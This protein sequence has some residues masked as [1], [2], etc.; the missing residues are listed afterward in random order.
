MSRADVSRRVTPTVD[1]LVRCDPVDGTRSWWHT[2]RWVGTKRAFSIWK[3]SSPAGRSP[4]PNLPYTRANKRLH[5][6]LK[7][8]AEGERVTRL[9]HE[10]EDRG[11]R[12]STEGWG[13]RRWRNDAARCQLLSS[14]RPDTR[15]SSTIVPLCSCRENKSAGWTRMERGKVAGTK[16]RT[17]WKRVWARMDRWTEVVDASGQTHLPLKQATRVETVFL[18]QQPA[19][20]VWIWAKESD[21]VGGWIVSRGRVPCDEPPLYVFSWNFCCNVNDFYFSSSV[22]P[23]VLFAFLRAHL[24]A[25]EWQTFPRGKGFYELAA[26][27]TPWSMIRIGRSTCSFL[28]QEKKLEKISFLFRL[29]IVPCYN[30]EVYRRIIHNIK[31][32]RKFGNSLQL[33]ITHQLFTIF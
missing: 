26:R 33:F 30:G 3:K 2:W 17:E 5:L 7:K 24:Y 31:K 12:K 25:R 1:F 20:G 11:G 32:L 19:R 23:P 16:R 8:H 29:S 22:S 28:H 15:P 4:R 10:A 27:A 21:T 13:W 18:Q 6:A 9:W 14:P